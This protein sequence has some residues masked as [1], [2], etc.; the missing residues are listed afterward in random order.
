MQ[1]QCIIK[2]NELTSAA[3]GQWPWRGPELAVTFRMDRDDRV[4]SRRTERIYNQ[5]RG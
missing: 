1:R 4:V 3:P 2:L 5:S